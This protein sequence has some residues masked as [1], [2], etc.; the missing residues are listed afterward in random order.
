MASSADA[1][2][3]PVLE[4]PYA[5]GQGARKR[6]FKVTEKGLETWKWII[7][8]NET[9]SNRLGVPIVSSFDWVKDVASSPGSKVSISFRLMCKW[10]E[11]I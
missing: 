9:E 1:N 6:H 8:Y 7:G 3:A 10:P 4:S 2:A 5:K 11:L